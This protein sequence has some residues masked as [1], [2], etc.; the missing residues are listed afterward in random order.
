MAGRAGD[1]ALASAAFFLRDGFAVTG[2][3]QTLAALFFL[4]TAL[5]YR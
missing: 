4:V 5:G 3:G 2:G 1:G